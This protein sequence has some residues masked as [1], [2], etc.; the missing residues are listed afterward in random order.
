LAWDTG[1]IKN[2]GPSVKSLTLKLTLAFLVV[3]LTGIA[4]VAVLVWVITSAEFSRYVIARRLDEYTTILI[5]YYKINGSWDGVTDVLINKG[6]IAEKYP[7][8]A[9]PFPNLTG[10]Q[11]AGSLAFAGE[12]PGWNPANKANKN[13]NL[14]PVPFVLVDGNSRV[15][16]P[17]G[18]FGENAELPADAFPD[19]V[20]VSFNQVVVG[21]VVVTGHAPNPNPMEMSYLK[22]TNQALMIAAVGSGLIAILLGLLLARS[23]T[24]PVLDLTHAA[25]ALAAGRLTQPVPVRSQD[26]LGELTETFNSMSADLDRANRLRKQMTA[27]IAHD[28][29]TPL[30]VIIGY[31]EGMKDG[32]IKPTI[33]RFTAMYDEAIY[34]QRLVEDLRT[35]SLADAG[36]LSI[37]FQPVYP[38]EVIQRLAACFQ[39]QAEQKEIQLVTVVE[40]A[41]PAIS[42]DPERMQQALSNLVGNALRY[43]PAG[44][45]ITLSARRVDKEVCIEV[46]DSGAGIDAE[47]LPHVFDR[48]YRG[49]GARQES[50]SGLG[51]AIAKSIVELQ[52]G[53]I[54]ATSQGVDRGSLFSIRMPI[55]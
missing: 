23:I 32:V 26:E 42:I 21:Y 4:L 20:A 14:P 18:P 15:I 47:T 17:T 11:A 37:N 43:T 6:L 10:T 9:V 25:R 12:G 3:S 34:L 28:L 19:R 50:G 8:S 46:Q 2:K 16:V 36:E 22:R 49:D 31:L 33:K 40:P 54:S 1:S 29:R 53:H 48:F 44:G 27:D 24:R 51:L 52:K 41:L 35:L 45:S 5:D 38:E 39:H 7:F 13:W 55:P 30:S